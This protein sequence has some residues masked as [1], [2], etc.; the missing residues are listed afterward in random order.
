[1]KRSDRPEVVRGRFAGTAIGHDL[2]RDLLAFVQA[3]QAGAFH[4]ADMHEHILATVVRLDESV[5]LR[6]VKPLHGSRSHGSPFFRCEFQKPRANA[7]GS[8][9]FWR[10]SSVRRA[11][12]AARPSRSAE[13]RSARI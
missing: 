6:S 1:M 4:R 12:D 13:A 3:V 9:E 5:A 8:T 10:M 7:A 11:Q 2:E